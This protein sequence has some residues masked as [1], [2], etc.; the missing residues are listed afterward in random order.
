ME[1]ADA[2]VSETSLARAIVAAVRRVAGVADVSP[3]RFAEAA[4]YG[5]NEKVQGVVVKRTASG[6]DVQIYLCAQYAS[7]LVLEDLAERVRVAART[8]AASTGASG[9]GRIDVI[10]DDLRFE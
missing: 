1:H 7:S 3:G 6:F 10:F 4:T 8:S 5:P 2:P 9:L